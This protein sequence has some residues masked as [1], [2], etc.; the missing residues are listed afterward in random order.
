MSVTAVTRGSR[1]TLSRTG[2]P[3]EPAPTW[4]RWATTN[5]LAR[6]DAKP[7]AAY[8]SFRLRQRPFAGLVPDLVTGQPAPGGLQGEHT[9]EP[10]RVPAA[11][12]AR[13]ALPSQTE[14]LALEQVGAVLQRRQDAGFRRHRGI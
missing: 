7:Q 5:L 4:S 6:P 3:P 10:R 13:A 9:G 1:Q 12:G 2:I 14:G 11:G 8:G